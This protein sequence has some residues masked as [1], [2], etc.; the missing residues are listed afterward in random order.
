MWAIINSDAMGL[1]IC[2]V[3]GH[4]DCG[5]KGWLIMSSGEGV[6]VSL[7][8]IAAIPVLPGVLHVEALALLS[9]F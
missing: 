4:S 3:V 1:A 8:G 6:A 9:F 5:R 2:R 7:I